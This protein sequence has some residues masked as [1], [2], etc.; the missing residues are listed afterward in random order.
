MAQQNAP[1]MPADQIE[2]ILLHELAHIRRHD[3]LVNM[4]QTFA[5]GFL[6]YH[7]AV[8]WISGRIRVE[9]EHCCDDLAVAAHGDA[10]PYAVALTALAHKKWKAERIALGATGGTLMKRVRRLLQEPERPRSGIMPVLT[11]CTMTRACRIAVMGHEAQLSAAPQEQT[12]SSYAKWLKEDVVYIISGAEAAAFLRLGTDEEREHFIKQFW[13]RRDP[14][15]GTLRNE[16][17]D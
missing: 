13:E 3:Y 9:R 7:P 17:K 6:F 4:V 10:H 2:S 1:Q 11:V 14:R 15:A 12:E 16:F 5:E 8:W